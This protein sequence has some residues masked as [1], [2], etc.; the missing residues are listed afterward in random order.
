MTFIKTLLRLK[1]QFL[2]KLNCNDIY[3]RL[4]F[5]TALTLAASLVIWFL[6]DVF[7]FEDKRVY[8]ILGIAL[9]FLLKLLWIDLGSPSPFQYEDER[10]QQGLLTMFNRFMGALRFLKKTT[11]TRHGK[12]MRLNALPWYL[13]VGPANAGKT[14]LLTHSH[15]NF[16][17]QRHTPSHH[18][19]CDWWVTRDATIIDVPGRYTS[20]ANQ[21]Q[22][23]FGVLWSFFLRL[24]KK[25]R[26]STGLNG[27]VIALP[28]PDVM[29]SDSKSFEHTLQGLCAR[30]SEIQ[31]YFDYE[32]PCQLV[33]TQCD[34]LAGFTDYFSDFADDE[35]NQA[36]GLQ[37]TDL[38]SHEKI[39]EA[40]THRF[41]LLIK[42]LNQQLISRLHHERNSSAR[43]AIKDFPLELERL[44]ENMAEIIKRLST[45]SLNLAIQGI[46]LTSALQPAPATEELAIEGHSN[47]HRPALLFKKPYAASRAYFIKQFVTHAIAS[48]R[49]EAEI[50]PPER[51]KR[52]LSY[53]ASILVIGL[54][55][56]ILGKDFE[57]GIKKTYTMQND[58][59]NYQLAIR[60]FNNPEEHLIKTLGL[61]DALQQS[62][63]KAQFKF[64]TAHL[65]SF[66]SFKSQE[67]ALL[68][69]H[70]ALRVILLPEIK[71]Y[72]ENYLRMPVN[73]NNDA[74]YATLKAYLMLSDGAH[75]EPEFIAHAVQNITPNFIDVNEAT[76]LSAHIREAFTSNPQALL[77]NADTIQK[78]RTYL[79]ALP[80]LQLS[81]ILLKNIGENSKKTTID[82][83]FNSKGS[84]IF[85]SRNITPQISMM[86]TGK[87]FAHILSQDIPTATNEALNGNWV[88]GNLDSTKKS[89]AETTTLT[90]QLQTM[91]VTKYA[92]VWD[93]L[94]STIYLSTPNNLDQADTIINNLTSAHSPLVSLLQMVHSNTGFDQITSV[95]TKLF[96]LNALTNKTG[97]DQGL[98][99]QVVSS[100]QSLHQYLRPVLNASNQQKAAF[101][102]LA[103]RMQHSGTADPITH[104]RLLADKTPEPV[105]SWLNKLTDDTWH[106]MMEYS[107]NYLNTA[108]QNQVYDY[109]QRE[110]A[111]RYPFVADADSDVN[112]QKFT[113]FF[114]NPGI[115]VSFYHHYLQNFVD[116]SGNDWRWKPMIGGKS[117]FTDSALRQ[118]QQAMR[119]Q[120]TFFPN[121]DNKLYVRF[122]LQPYQLSKQIARVQLKINDKKLSDEHNG[123]HSPHVLMWPSASNV[124]MTSIEAVLMN[125][126]TINREF[127]GEW[128]WFKLVNQSI[129]NAANRH[130]SILD[131]ST[132]G[133]PAK[134]LFFTEGQYNAFLTP[135]MKNFGLPKQLIGNDKQNA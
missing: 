35:I 113:D 33:I 7:S 118:I 40:F 122:A 135:N 37:L 92:A 112:L 107:G 43:P 67:K 4:T 10:V 66:Y 44:K 11:I 70:Q 58:V 16:V 53:A 49:P 60:Q 47:I 75:L 99:I 81:F 134:Y 97:T 83:G 26:G 123:G 50:A 120:R 74:V 108:W 15:V 132:N 110:I 93:A 133:I 129:D 25:Y 105:K 103:A 95:N 21:Q 109:Y 87:L 27:L 38:E 63:E 85:A 48:L 126:K 62:V 22:S 101:D 45:P 59:A 13:L 56:F 17:L 125:N 5:Y 72:L 84:N 130:Q 86:Y 88:L 131:F 55:A 46:Y 98:M 119:I 64:D 8:A 57:R 12:S 6:G 14:S 127:P 128:G 61:L 71:S 41:H 3:A 20:A 68:A 42:R 91:Y 90:Q 100:L 9:A 18:D 54:A 106:L 19:N 52:R 29:Q 51:W 80:S 78:T 65:F 82:F 104:V 36:W 24:I 34:K 30:I 114:G 116:T 94:L 73:K 2:T 117:I 96:N 102:L 115:L 39:E 1:N 69:Y 77:L 32:L 23:G 79:S 76:K 28:L 124:K 121:G 111:N 89:L 31:N